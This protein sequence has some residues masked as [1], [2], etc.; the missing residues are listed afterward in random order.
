M[1][2]TRNI[3]FRL[4]VKPPWR[5]IIPASILLFLF[6][7]WYPLWSPG[8]KI[9]D[10]RHDLK[11]NA[12]W[13]QHGWL[14]DNNWLERNNK[15]SSLFRSQDHIQKLASL[16]KKNNIQYVFP[17]MCPC[18]RDGTLPPID[19]EQT[20]LFLEEM[21]DFK[22]LP[23]V[24]GVLDEQ[25]ILNSQEWR[26]NFITSIVELL[27][28]HPQFDGIH[29][30]IE[31]LPSGTEEFVALIKELR[32]QFPKEKILS[33]AAY[34]PPTRFHSF[35]EV[36][37]EKAYY[38]EINQYADQI[39]VMM[40]DTAI[41]WKKVYQ[42]IMSIWTQE[43]L[44]WAPNSM[45]LLGVSGYEDDFDYHNPEVENIEN[46]LLGIHAGLSRHRELP[47]NY[48]GVAIYC[49]WEMTDEKW[50]VFEKMFLEK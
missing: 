1:K 25:V 18:K 8:E 11:Q 43:V 21:S 12:I 47:N 48:V 49:E 33:V 37:W 39:V 46:G 5:T 3:F 19:S 44:T 34:P 23:W 40:Y 45:I 17:H 35:P 9:I 13:I 10:G 29:I 22:I 7:I 50:N 28:K 36:H 15:N 14:A 6:L 41:Q 4:F 38:Q 2:E 20:Y 32:E 42:Y 31:P 26:K 24:G 30:N 16:L 27:N